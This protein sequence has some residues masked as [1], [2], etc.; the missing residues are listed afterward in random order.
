VFY[1]SNIR[2]GSETLGNHLSGCM[3]RSKNISVSNSLSPI[4]PSVT[5][6]NNNNNNK[7]RIRERKP[8]RLDSRRFFE[9]LSTTNLSESLSVF[10]HVSLP[11]VTV[12][13]D[14]NPSCNSTMRACALMSGSET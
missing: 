8:Q 12:D 13:D 1:Y 11:P 10:W 9:S 6:D 4:L 5:N 2:G 3:G 7:K 14:W